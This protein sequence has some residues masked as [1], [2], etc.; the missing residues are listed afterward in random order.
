VLASET[1]GVPLTVRDAV[2]TRIA[3]LSAH[4]RSLL[5][6]VSVIP[7]RTEH[8]LLEAVLS[9]TA[10]AVE[11]CVTH[12]MLD[13]S[14]TT[15]AFRHEQ[16]RLA[17]ES[18]LS[19]LRKQALHAQLLQGLLSHGADAEHPARL[20]HHAT[21]A[22][23][24]ALV[25]RYAP[26]AA[27]H[28]A[29]Q[30]A[31]RQAA[32]HYR[33]ALGYAD[34]LD[35]SG[36]Q[37]LHAT[38]LDGLA[39]ECSLTSQVEEAFRAHS[40]ALVLWRCLD[41]TVQV[42]YTLY[43]LSGHSWHLGRSE[44]AC[45]YAVE[46]VEL[47]ETLPPS[48]E[49]GQAY[50]KLS[51]QHMVTSN[52]EE[53][54]V[55]GRR[56]IEVAQQFHDAQTECYALFSIGSTTFCSGEERGRVML[57]QSL[58]LAKEQGFEE[59][60]ALAYTNLADARIRS[61]VYAQATGYLQEG[62]A[63]CTE[64]D[65]DTFGY[66]LRGERARA[67]L[68]QGDWVG[69]E[70]DTTAILSVPELATTNRLPALLVLSLLRMRRGDPGAQQVLDEARDLAAATGDMQDITPVAA[71]RAE[72]RWLQGQQEQC[73]AEATK[74]FQ[75]A[76]PCQRP[77]YLGEVAI[78]LWRGGRMLDVPEVA[79]DPPFAL[80]IAGDWRGAA[81]LWEQIGCPY[82]QALALA[83]GDAEAMREALALFERLGAQ[84]AV[85]RMRR[86]LRQQGI[87]G[88]PRGPRPSTRTNQA[89]LTMRQLE[90]LQLM[91]EGLPNTE[92]ASRLFTSLKTVEH[93]V[94]A[95]LT[96]LGVHSRAQ[97]VRAASQMALLPNMGSQKSNIGNS[98]DASTIK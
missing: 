58:H 78:W 55:W 17:V 67:H 42:G 1:E 74:G 43:R 91:A 83:D 75:V 59:I 53:T 57:E 82:E 10:Q 86:R 11:E 95:V 87:A 7:S 25:L 69:A 16:A 79:I 12:G 70:E 76:L 54:L 29:A 47:L 94:S 88:I 22:H 9:S 20:A 66:C 62:M 84:P 6:L 35:A 38:F 52:T 61:R 37:E 2:L 21:G 39:N 65:L 13:L 4:A 68:D 50:A 97:A 32:E 15:V 48:R 81:E 8:W 85:A 96:K 80:Q 73:V 14:R 31:H 64:H 93:H 33:R 5:E 90:V 46:A 51:S 26:L 3:R 23:D 77:W 40:A 30:G 72:W 63:Y 98:S 44:K 36:Q 45:R 92:I 28:A 71:A 49:L 89:G 56:A 24:E 19:P 41:R 60:A 18:T 27:R 34:L